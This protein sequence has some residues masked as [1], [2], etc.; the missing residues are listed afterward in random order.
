M[1]RVLAGE[2]LVL[3][4]NWVNWRKKNW[5]VVMTAHGSTESSSQRDPAA[6]IPAKTTISGL[7]E[8]NLCETNI[9]LGRITVIAST[10]H[11]DWP[12]ELKVKPGFFL[13]MFRVFSE[14][15]RAVKRSSSQRARN[16]Y[17]V[18]LIP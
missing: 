3:D 1:Q 14:P 5:C 12:R 2:R 18:W 7:V 13:V 16:T 9:S 4:V 6:E 8:Q 11:T 10:C 15:G 17:R